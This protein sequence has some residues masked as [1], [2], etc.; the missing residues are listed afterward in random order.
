MRYGITDSFE[1]PHVEQLAK[2]NVN[3]RINNEMLILLTEIG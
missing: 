3:T 2:R 1:T